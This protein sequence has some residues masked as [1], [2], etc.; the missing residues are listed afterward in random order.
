MGQTSRELF[1]IIANPTGILL[2]PLC[3][4]QS[5][6]TVRFPI[7]SLFITMTMTQIVPSVLGPFESSAGDNQ[8]SQVHCPLGMRPIKFCEILYMVTSYIWI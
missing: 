3:I 4:K 2:K 6:K 7:P 1:D 5:N 8:V